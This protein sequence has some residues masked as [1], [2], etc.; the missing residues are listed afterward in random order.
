MQLLIYFI[1]LFCLL[2]FSILPFKVLY[3]FSDLLR[4][5]FYHIIHYRRKIIIENLKNSFPDKA[6]TER[7][8]ML[9]DIY[10]NLMDIVL[11]SMRGLTMSS[12]AVINRYKI[13][14]PEL[15]NDYYKQ[16]RS[17][18]CVAAHYCNW[19]WGAFSGAS[20][21]Q[22]KIVALYKPMSNKYIDGFMQEKRAKAKVTMASI[23]ETTT[24][25]ETYSKDVCAFVMVADQS[26]T[27]FEKAF[28]INFL[29]QDTA[30]LHGPEKHA[31]KYDTPVLYLDIQR[32]KRGFYAVEASLLSDNPSLLKDG[33]ITRKYMSK[34]ESIIRKKPE[35][36]LWSHRRWKHKREVE[37]V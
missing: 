21:L 26:P 20:Q 15:I 32:V 8:K 17:V 13:L 11:E 31:K 1:F 5:L 18:V 30:C 16:G 25:F 35:N 33:E 14:N 34:L 9:N 28:W 29:N 24:T 27:N 19:E 12:K 3:A 10:R 23:Y 37:I 7:L 36:W 2:L 22:H 4:F 6:Q